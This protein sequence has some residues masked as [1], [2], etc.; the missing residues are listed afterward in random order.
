M[1]NVCVCL[2][3]ARSVQWL[4]VE[5]INSLHLSQNFQTLETGGLVEI[6]GDGTGLT[7]GWHQVVHALDLC[8]FP[9]SALSRYT[10][11]PLML[12]HSPSRGCSW[13][14][15]SPTLGSLEEA[16]RVL[17]VCYVGLSRRCSVE[18]LGAVHWRA[19]SAKDRVA[20]GR[21][22][23]RLASAG[24]ARRRNMATVRVDCNASAQDCESESFGD[25]VGLIRVARAKWFSSR[26][27]S[28]PFTCPF[29]FVF[30]TIDDY[31]FCTSVLELQCWNRNESK[32]PGLY[33]HKSLP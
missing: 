6:G 14:D 15:F 11:L 20:A 23:A 3:F 16:A 12:S 2:T 22:M 5:D 9:P 10:R 21:I 19:V 8:V 18:P 4:H 30:P 17:V 31:N 33:M 27:C 28:S 32:R 7:T 1:G 13:L 26:R 24:A 29:H 25:V